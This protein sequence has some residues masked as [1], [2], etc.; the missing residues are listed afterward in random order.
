MTLSKLERY[1]EILK[2]I[3]NSC[4]LRFS[5]P[6]K[7]SSEEIILSK[8]D[9]D[10]LMKQRTIVECGKGNPTAY[11]ITRRG[12]AVIKYLCQ[13]QENSIGQMQNC[14]HLKTIQPADLVFESAPP[15][16]PC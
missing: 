12:K 15:K 1:I 16:M 8:V 9:I 11:R 14:Y 3:D 2:M 4:T 7:T 13:N 10:F 5:K 6:I